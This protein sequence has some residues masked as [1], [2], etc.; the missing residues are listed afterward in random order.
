MKKPLKAAAV[1]LTA[2]MMMSVV[3]SCYTSGGNVN[4][5]SE[6]DP[7]YNLTAIEIDPGINRD[8]YEYAYNEF[9]TKLDD[10]YVYEMTGILRLPEDFDYDHDDYS[11]YEVENLNFFD[12]N[13]N[14]VESISVMDH[15]KEYDIEGV[16]Y[17]NGV[18]KM[19][20]E[21]RVDFMTYDMTS[22]DQTTY[23]CTVDTNTFELSAPET[24][25][26]YDFVDRMSEDGNEESAAILGSY[27]IRKFW[28]Y[29]GDEPSYVLEVIDA[30]DNVT[31]ID[32]REE[33][34]NQPI[35]DIP[36][37]VEYGENKALIFANYDGK[38][39]FFSLDFTTMKITDITDQMS[40]FN[41]DT[42]DV[43]QVEG[44]GSVLMDDLGLYT[45]DFEGQSVES[46]FNFSDSNVNIYDISYFVPIDVTE[47]EAVFAG[48]VYSDNPS[49]YGDD[50]TSWIYIFNKADS[51]PNAGKTVL[52]IAV[53]D[54]Y[55]R[56]LCGAVCLFNETNDTYYLKYND[57]YR[58]NDQIDRDYDT[59]EEYEL[60]S[61]KASAEL[62]NR[63]SIDLMSGTGP[64]IIID[65]STFGMLNDDDYLLNLSEYVSTNYGSDRYFSNV[66]D[67]A[68]I[69]GEL[70]QLPLSFNITGI[71][72]PASY[73]EDGQVGFTFEQFS[74]FIDNECNGQNP[75][76]GGKLSLFI[77][78]L[79]CMQDLVITGDTVNYDTE[80]FRALAEY[81]AENVNDE[82]VVSEDDSYDGMS[83]DEGPS[84]VY[85]TE[86]VDYY[87]YIL[88]D[89][90]V[91][92]GVPSYDGRGPIIYGEG[93][94]AVSAN[95]A[96]EEGCMQ[97]VDLLMGDEVQ[98]MFGMNYG[99]PV[100]RAA[101][102]SV[103]SKLIDAQ[104]ATLQELLRYYDEDML[105]MYGYT[106]DIMDEEGIADF[107]AMIETLS[108]WYT[109]DGAINA[110]IREE[111]PAYF[112]GQKTLDQVIPV[113]ED[114]V[115]T[116]LNERLG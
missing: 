113:V 65:A 90:N 100:N 36:T 87:N 34:P 85:I 42:S 32:L 53:I 16:I 35:Y 74:D 64:D 92:L 108:G 7:W 81:V 6:D 10:Y 27:T 9:I 103:G 68:N 31:E 97:F 18:E 91:L 5:I 80:A 51:N 101:F 60:A 102:N 109:N 39:L 25:G 19:D 75:I 104:N 13:G 24:A 38:N 21:L 58:L 106:T 86:V 70:Y 8:D 37:I 62:G 67:A 40:W 47:D 26:D 45:I 52:S 61:D 41:N 55:S 12:L 115:Q 105:R 22:G 78:A 73:V 69:D 114:R 59:D 57:S 77:T 50:S 14:L 99:I 82:L 44:M 98:D 17:I 54:D 88:K 112:E 79:N 48:E 15:L 29:G 94:V 93:S 28:M 116:I 46:L 4:V 63:L 96:S 110:I 49:V 95:S 66:F 76:S 1:G 111:M 89:D 30:D 23:R 2:A 3:T 107:A 33:F 20:G 72:A 56:A 71:A 43:C 83:S 11:Q 84:L